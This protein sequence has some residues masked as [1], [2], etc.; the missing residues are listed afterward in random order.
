[1]LLAGDDAQQRCLPATV[2]TDQ[3][4]AL[5]RVD[6]EGDAVQGGIASKG[7]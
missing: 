7:L 3:T 6:H 5:T 1:M 4:H 2:G